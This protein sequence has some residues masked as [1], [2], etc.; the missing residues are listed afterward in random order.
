MTAPDQTEAGSELAY[1]CVSPLSSPQQS[2]RWEVTDWHGE[3]LQFDTGNFWSCL[4]FKITFLS[5]AEDPEVL[6]VYVTALL[7]MTARRSARILNLKCVAS[8]YLGYVED[9]SQEYLP[10][11]F[12]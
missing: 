4:E 12:K 5:H 3:V 1:K 7:F 8:N 10:C 9:L 6:D 2:I 11:K